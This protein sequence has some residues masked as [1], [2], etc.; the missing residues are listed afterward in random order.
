MITPLDFPKA[1][2]R[3]KRKNGKVYVWCAIR[4]LDLLCTPEE[5]VRQ[6][7][8]HYLINKKKI[9]I[10]LIVS[11]YSLNYNG[12]N[13]RADIVVLDR[14]QNPVLIVECKAPEIPVNDK[15][16]LQIAQYNAKL[17]ANYLFLTNGL[18]HI[19]CKVDIGKLV[20]LDELPEDIV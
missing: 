12:V 20:I 6:H 9:P 8:I 17:N 15:V 4:K 14:S 18:N 11:E 10:G 3:L 16:M 5:W 19:V 1:P 13:K 7:V 2:L